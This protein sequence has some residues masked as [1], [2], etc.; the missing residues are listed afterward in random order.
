MQFCDAEATA[1]F[2]NR[3]SLCVPN[4]FFGSCFYRDKCS[5]KHKIVNNDKVKP[6][7]DLV[8]KFINNPEKLLEGQ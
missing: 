8:D 1:V 6:I 7:L 4:A 5:R 3:T 2:P